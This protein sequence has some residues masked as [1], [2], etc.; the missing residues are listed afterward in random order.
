[1]GYSILLHFIR[2]F[3]YKDEVTLYLSV[4]KDITN[5]YVYRCLCG[6]PSCNNLTAHFHLSLKV[7]KIMYIFKYYL[8]MQELLYINI[9]QG[10]IPIYIYSFL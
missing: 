3:L 7:F 6:I 2:F 1:M 9:K 10:L 8:A 4:C 5:I